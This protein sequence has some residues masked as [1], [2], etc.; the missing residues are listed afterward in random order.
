MKAALVGTS[1]A[2]RLYYI[3]DAKADEKDGAIEKADG[4]VIKV[5]FQSYIV[6]TRGIK[7]NNFRYFRQITRH[8][9]FAKLDYFKY[10]I[11]L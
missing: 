5:D 11:H 8:L 6:R 2:G 9:I 7:R 1:S 10:T 3:T 4:T